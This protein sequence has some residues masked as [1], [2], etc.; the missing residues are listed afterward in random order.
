MKKLLKILPVVMVVCL[1]ATSVFAVSV[2]NSM[3]NGTAS[4]TVSK[5]TGNVWSTVVTVVQVLA[6]GCVVFAGLRYMFAFIPKRFLGGRLKRVSA[7]SVF[8]CP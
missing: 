3:P 8:S 4:T 1:V 2:P 7:E 5:L 6:V